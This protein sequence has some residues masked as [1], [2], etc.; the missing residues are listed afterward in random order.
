MKVLVGVDGSPNSFA[1][2][3]FVG[4]LLSP[5]R[6]EIV[7]LYAA[8]EMVAVD[9][10]R[11]DMAVLERARNALGQAILEEALRRLPQELHSRLATPT[12]VGHGQAAGP[13]LLEAIDKHKADLIAVG[14]HGTSGIV[15]SFVLGSVSRMV[16]HSAKIP[17]LIV[18]SEIAKETP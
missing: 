12:P 16:A 5:E 11:L 10:E 1:A 15:E 9:E 4:R 3:E 8:P 17:V 7:L 2:V 6:D 14:F 13:V 18:K